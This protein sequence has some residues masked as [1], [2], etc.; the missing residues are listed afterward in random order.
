MTVW[1]EQAHV[2]RAVVRV[3]AV[4]VIDVERDS[5]SAGVALVPATHGALF[6]ALFE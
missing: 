1:A 3:I 2:G 4:Y 5:A 6:T